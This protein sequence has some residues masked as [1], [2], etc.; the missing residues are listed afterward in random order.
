MLYQHLSQLQERN[1]HLQDSLSAET[2]IKLD[3]FSALGEVKRQL[4]I[5]NGK[6]M[7]CSFQ[8]RPRRRDHFVFAGAIREKERELIAA[9]HSQHQVTNSLFNGHPHSSGHSS[10][11]NHLIDTNNNST[12]SPSTVF[13]SPPT[14][15][16]PPPPL[17][18]ATSNLDPNAQDFCLSSHSTTNN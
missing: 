13:Y 4:E 7:N 1:A 10:P 5:A 8:K 9:L 17:T 12:V 2:R 18:N 14:T 11:T 6:H 15:I 3:L 16:T